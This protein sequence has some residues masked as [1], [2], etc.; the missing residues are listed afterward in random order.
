MNYIKLGKGDGAKVHTGG[1][2][3]GNKGFYIQPTIFTDAKP[4]MKIVQEEIFGPVAVIV[5]FKDEAEVIREAND[6]M[7]GLSSNIFTKDINRAT[8]ITNAIE[9]GSVYV[10]MAS[11]PDFRIPFGGFKQSG[12]GK[13]MGPEA[14]EG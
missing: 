3:Q 10:N 13:E 8:R 14:L 7:Y 12:H 9:S 2:Q 1:G 4:G 5:K 11:I 6:S